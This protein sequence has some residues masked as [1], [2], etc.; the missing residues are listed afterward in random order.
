MRSGGH[1]EKR[2]TSTDRPPL[3]WTPRL[4]VHSFCLLYILDVSICSFYASSM[5]R[6]TG[7]TTK[8][9]LNVGF[10]DFI[11]I[12]PSVILKA[13]YLPCYSHF[14]PKSLGSAH[15]LWLFFQ[16]QSL[17]EKALGSFFCI[18]KT[19]KSTT[20]GLPWCSVIKN[21]PADAVDTD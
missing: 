3:L 15:F 2:G 13:V 5:F 7:V 1:T 17:P 19:L 16:L 4:P 9:C 20:R 12:Y 21:P 8:S 6:W 11:L 18:I 10:S 14:T